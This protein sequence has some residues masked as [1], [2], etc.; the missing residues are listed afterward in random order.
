MEKINPEIF[1]LYD[2]RGAYP[3]DFNKETAYQIGRYLIHFLRAKNKKSRLK[4]VVGRDTRL[5]SPVLFKGFSDGVLDEGCD[6]IDIGLVTT[7]MLYFAISNF[8]YDG[9]VIITASH[10]PNPFNGLKLSREKAIPI[11][12]ETGIFLMRDY[13]AKNRF[14]RDAKSNLRGRVV[15]KS[16][17]NEYIN[18][19]IKLAGVK[20]GEIDGLS[21]A[22]DAGN[23]VGGLVT[24]KILKKMAVKTHC[25]YCL[26]DGSFP[27]H[28]PDPSL[29][30]NLRDI[31][32][33]TKKKKLTLGIALDGDADRIVFID[34]GG[35]PVSG[36][37]II[38]LMAKILLKSSG[39]GKILFDVRSSNAV[40]EVISENGGE[41]V[42]Y[43]IGHALIKEKMRQDNIFFGG[44]FSGHYYLG[45]DLFYEVPIF[46][47]L[48]ILKEIKKEKRVLSNLIKPYKRYYHSGEIN[49]EIKEKE[50]KKKEI[51]NLYRNG[52]TLEIDGLR[53]DFDDWW[54]LVR[55]SNTEP[56][57]RL[58]IE[59][60]TRAML[61][62]KK[63]ELIKII[64][65]PIISK[66]LIYRGLKNKAR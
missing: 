16:I 8:H 5:S 37:M 38:A 2:I 65:S 64:G 25:L 7:P 42:V 56:V 27:N 45:G 30:E 17:E 32:A 52:R 12:G 18:F 58:V 35:K 48:K 15:K 36:D 54:F 23:G 50:E 19:N 1:R 21:V 49:F 20:R 41:P 28:V 55:A 46:V 59:A 34:E 24:L 10:N 4:I 3:R 53:V 63:K 33:L 62:E 40:G 29:K 44:E 66:P 57:L 61:E 6:I 31:I 11:S 9:G 14:L 39:H 60:K 26:P 47:L 22:M 43:R 13:L 51:K